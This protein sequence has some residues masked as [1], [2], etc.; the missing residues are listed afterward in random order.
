MRIKVIG[1]SSSGNTII[2]DIGEDIFILDAGCSFNR[3][4]KRSLNFDISRIRFVISTHRHS[5]HAK[6]IQEYIYAGI[7]VYMPQD[8]KEKYKN[9]YAAVSIEPLKITIHGEFKIIPFIVPHDGDVICYAYLIEHMD[10]GKLLYMVDCLYCP[11]DLSKVG[12][13]HA[14]VECNHMYDLVDKDAP[15][16][17]HL[18]SGHMSDKI[19]FEFI[20]TINTDSLKT[21]LLCHLS[22]RNADSEDFLERI[23]KI[24]PT[25]VITAIAEKGLVMDL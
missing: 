24:V 20:R 10:F 19:C 11:Y 5:D 7:T 3:N 16:Y 2:C 15:N 9:D 13:N 22:V 23:N 1:S 21:V 17:E 25:G 12:I 4:V 6:Y 8:L 14:F 18:L